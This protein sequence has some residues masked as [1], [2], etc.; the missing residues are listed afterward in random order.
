MALAWLS[1]LLLA[2]GCE[3][4][5]ESRIRQNPHVYNQLDPEDQYKIQQGVI[6]LGYSPDMV[7][8]ALGAP[9]QRRD[10]LTSEGLRQ[11]WIYNTF[12][13]RYEGT[14]HVGYRRQLY[15][16]RF[17]GRYRI[18]YAP[19][20]ADAYRPHLEEQIQVEFFNGR[21]VAVEQAR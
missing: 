8:L 12:Y 5:R 15:Y 4:A 17:H 7:Y 11:V 1:A 16:D 19:V 20:Y 2:A 14:R 13:E 3:S 6:D 9:D 18:H 21:V 10:T